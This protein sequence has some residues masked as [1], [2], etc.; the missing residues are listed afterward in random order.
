MSKKKKTKNTIS[1]ANNG[2]KEIR[3]GAADI[4]NVNASIGGGGIGANCLSAIHNN[5]TTSSTHI[6][7]S[8]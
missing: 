8:S 4:G 6:K 3:G 7:N 1:E 2:S 5:T